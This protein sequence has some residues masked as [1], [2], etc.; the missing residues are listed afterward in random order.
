MRILGLLLLS[1]EKQE[2]IQA[3][4]G[5]I[6]GTLRAV[7]MGDASGIHVLSRYIGTTGANS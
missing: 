3:F 2:G 5:V 6:Q 7:E 4:Q 1:I